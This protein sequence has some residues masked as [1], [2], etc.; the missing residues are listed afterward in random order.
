VTYVKLLS[1][2]QTLAAGLPLADKL[3]TARVCNRRRCWRVLLCGGAQRLLLW[4]C[5]R[6]GHRLLFYAA[7]ARKQRCDVL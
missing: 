6:G 1:R 2:G 7:H 4:C 3:I 5:S